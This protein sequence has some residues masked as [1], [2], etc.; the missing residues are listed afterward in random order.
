MVICT[1]AKE[2]LM[3]IQ[4]LARLNFQN[5]SHL[6]AYSIIIV[7]TRH[8]ESWTLSFLTIFRFNPP[9]FQR[10]ALRLLFFAHFN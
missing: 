5:R 7:I 2:L 3:P 1:I 6:L 9:G 10:T 4:Y 8:N